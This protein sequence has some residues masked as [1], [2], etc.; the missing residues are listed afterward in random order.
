MYNVTHYKKLEIVL[1]KMVNLKNF[2]IQTLLII[3]LVIN[4]SNFALSSTKQE[5][6]SSPQDQ[7][8][9]AISLEKEKKIEEAKKWYQKA[10]EQG[11]A[12]AQYNLGTIL[13]KEGKRQEAKE[14][15]IKA[16]KQGEHSFNLLRNKEKSS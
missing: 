16:A 4:F 5:E 13:Y 6:T 15:F 7:Y 3:L 9:L 2:V 14:W 11:H 8:D 1:I 10:A 12:K